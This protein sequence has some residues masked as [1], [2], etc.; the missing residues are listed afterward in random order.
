MSPVLHNGDT[1]LVNRLSYL[2]KKPHIDD[3]IAVFDPRDHK[4][5]IKRITKIEHNRY[6]VEGDNKKASTDSRKFGMLEKKDI[7]GKVVNIG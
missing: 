6:F 5:L 1:V 7:I 3:I 2:F 4:I